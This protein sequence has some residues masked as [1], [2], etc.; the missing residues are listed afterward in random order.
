MAEAWVTVM[1]LSAPSV[2]RTMP[3]EDEPFEVDGGCTE[4]HEQCIFVAAPVKCARLVKSVAS[5]TVSVSAESVPSSATVVM[6]RKPLETYKATY[7]TAL[8]PTIA[9][10]RACSRRAWT[11]T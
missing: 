5:T 6:G 3:G 8:A 10:S 11:A 4:A 1:S 7:A 2:P 9:T